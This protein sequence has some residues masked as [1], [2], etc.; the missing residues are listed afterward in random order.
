MSSSTKSGPAD[1]PVLPSNKDTCVRKLQP[2]GNPAYV[3]KCFRTCT[4]MAHEL[5]IHNRVL[6]VCPALTVRI[7]TDLNF[8][9][10]DVCSACWATKNNV[11]KLI[12]LTAVPGQKTGPASKKIEFGCP[13]I[14]YEDGGASLATI[15]EGADT[16]HTLD[17][18]WKLVRAAGTI[19]E[20]LEKLAGEE[21][22]HRDVKP[23]NV[24][25]REDSNQ[26]R[27]I[28]FG[29]GVDKKRTTADPFDGSGTPG[30]MPPEVAWFSSSAMKEKLVD[31]YMETW[32][33][34]FRLVTGREL[35]TYS[36]W[37]HMDT[38]FDRSKRVLDCKKYDTYSWGLV[39]M[40]LYFR[41]GAAEAAY[42]GDTELKDRTV[43]K[44]VA[45]LI[46]DM[47]HP[48]NKKRIGPSEA[49]LRYL[50]IS[51]YIQKNNLP[52]TPPCP[53]IGQLR[54]DVRSMDLGRIRNTCRGI[55]RLLKEKLS[56]GMAQ[57]D[58]VGGQDNGTV[59]VKKDTSGQTVQVFGTSV[60]P[61]P[62]NPGTSIS[63]RDGGPDIGSISLDHLYTE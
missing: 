59:V 26:L 33:S 47:V 23:S 10:G 9:S 14:R 17:F 36:E 25:Y 61:S 62:Q 22:V 32:S 11:S 19:F 50:N 2:D 60:N 13:P 12:H 38:K 31:E 7:L 41:L 45:S 58:P 39:L 16:G 24:V 30:Y 28:D 15:I 56:I 52:L 55:V 43:L 21:I 3:S 42:A 57:V 44:M 63:D 4:E 34:R 54:D 27:L 51:E 29:I 8:N 40:G 48:S 20:G 49:R 1:D 53:S 35:S 37:A 46:R 5:Y 6:E 18:F